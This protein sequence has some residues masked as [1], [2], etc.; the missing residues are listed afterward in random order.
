MLVIKVELHSAITGKVSELA[1]MVI[2]NK[3][4]G[5][6]KRGDYKAVALRK[7]PNGEVPTTV[8]AKDSDIFR[9]T[10]IEDYPRESKHVWCLVARALNQMGF[11]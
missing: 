5:T 7:R 9:Q 4:S 8:L 1:R 2:A 10:D 3:G 11:K 6:R